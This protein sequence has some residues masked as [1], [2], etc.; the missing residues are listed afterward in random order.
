MGTSLSKLNGNFLE[1]KGPM[2]PRTGPLSV[3]R[4]FYLE[5]GSQVLW[6]A[7]DFFF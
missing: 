4:C 5:D 1:A 3:G 7:W 6:D 2:G